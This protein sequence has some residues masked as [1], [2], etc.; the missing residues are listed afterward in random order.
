MVCCTKKRD[1]TLA[2]GNTAFHNKVLSNRCTLTLGMPQL[3]NCHN[4]ADAVTCTSELKRLDL[5]EKP[6]SCRNSSFFTCLMSDDSPSARDVPRASI[7]SKNITVGPF[8]RRALSNSFAT[9]LA[10][11]PWYL[12]TMSAADT[13]TANHCTD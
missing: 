2:C 4:G 9:F 6:S 13:D 5:D 10:D 8:C 3:Q 12:E 1:W 7:S 11:S